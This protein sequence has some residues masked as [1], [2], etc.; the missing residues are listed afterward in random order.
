MALNPD[1]VIGGNIRKA[2]AVA[3]LSQ[4]GL[5]VHLGISPQQVSKFELGLDRVS[6]SQLITVADCLGVGVLDLMTGVAAELPT[7]RSDHLL[8]GDYKALAARTRGAVRELVRAIVEETAR[9]M[10]S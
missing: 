3:G 6:A 4:R 5:G 2:R 10:K 8:M 1:K 9:G 7:D